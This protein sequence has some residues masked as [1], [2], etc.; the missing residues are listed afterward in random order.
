MRRSSIISPLLLFSFIFSLISPA[1]LLSQD[2]PQKA[3]IALLELD[4]RG[5]LKDEECALLSDAIRQE[6][7]YS[8]SYRIIDRR[9]MALILSEQGFQISDCTTEECAVKVGRLL[10]VDKMAVGSIGKLGKVF[11]LN[12][13]ILDVE[14]GEIVEMVSDKCPCTIE[15]LH[16]RV[17]I[18]AQKLTGPSIPSEKITPPPL[19]PAPEPAVGKLRISSTP[20]GA[21]ISLDG[22][23]SGRT[24]S[25]LSDLKPKDYKVLLKL[26]NYLAHEESVSVSPGEETKVDVTLEPI[27]KP[28][29]T[30][31]PVSKPKKSASIGKPWYK[32]VWVWAVV[33]GAIGAGTG[34]GIYLMGG[35][36]E[37]TTG[38]IDIYL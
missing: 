4:N 30:E 24:P 11:I 32:K 21:D 17:K 5:G 6:F 8:D 28:R 23:D 16:D 34:A 20:E 29:V 36:E 37:S 26:N 25:L 7:F 13:Q 33:V 15:E 2:S 22:K 1:Q 35:D 14:T 31:A 38:S 19:P 3:F 27:Q 12:L 10:G 18:M 9:N